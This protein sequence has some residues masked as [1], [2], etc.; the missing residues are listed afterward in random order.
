MLITCLWMTKK[1]ATLSILFFPFL[2]QLGY[3][4]QRSPESF[5]PIELLWYKRGWS[6]PGLSTIWSLDIS[7]Q[8]EL[9]TIIH[10]RK[11]TDV[12]MRIA[13]LILVFLTTA[14]S[15]TRARIDHV[16]NLIN[17]YGKNPIIQP[18]CTSL[19]LLSLTVCITSILFLVIEQSKIDL[20]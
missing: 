3:F 8:I 6:V 1:T 14:Q 4:S 12:M 10:R 5:D 20:G 18:W 13:F 7:A 16:D 19:F 9:L 15:K 11:G 2:R 17:K